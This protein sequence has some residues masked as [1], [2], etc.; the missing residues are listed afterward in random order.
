MPSPH[1]ARSLPPRS[2]RGSDSRR[3][4][5]TQV[6]EHGA[7]HSGNDCTRAP[8]STEPPAGEGIIYFA[9]VG[10]RSTAHNIQ[11]AKSRRNLKTE[12][13]ARRIGRSGGAGRDAA[14]G[15]AGTLGVSAPYPPPTA[16]SCHSS[17]TPL[18]ACGPRSTKAIWA[19]ATRSLTV[20]VTSTSPGRATACTRAAI[21]RTVHHLRWRCSGMTS[22]RYSMP[23]VRTTRSCSRPGT[24]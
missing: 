11:S 19:P 13:T 5:E 7:Q 14:G 15:R 10:I 3:F 21:C 16:N 23:L 4:G 22:A 18:R 2:P 12:S 8:E 6:R 20:R 1:V 17:G 9:V 24:W